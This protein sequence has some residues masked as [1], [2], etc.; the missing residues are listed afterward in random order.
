MERVEVYVKDRDII[1]FEMELTAHR[2]LMA[3]V[4]TCQH[5]IGILRSGRSKRGK[6]KKFFEAALLRGDQHVQEQID[7]LDT[8]Q[9]QETKMSAAVTVT[10][11]KKTALDVK[12]VGADVKI[13][14]GGIN[15]V[16]EK[17]SISEATTTEERIKKELKAKLGVE[18]SVLKTL[19]SQY[20]D[21]REKLKPGTCAWLK[22]DSQYIL[23]H[24]A[25]CT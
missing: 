14:S 18:D 7:I 13:V 5:C 11:V 9:E 20:R 16:N 10:T 8:L 17:L 15:S 21:R 25:N 24:G 23:T 4:K 22:D 2:M 6:T 3:V 1:G 12:D 19:Q